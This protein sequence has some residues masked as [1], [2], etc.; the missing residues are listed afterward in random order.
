M[1]AVLPDQ[2]VQGRQ[3]RAVRQR[4]RHPPSGASP[5][6]GAEG[7]VLRPA[8]Q[9]VPRSD[10]P[11]GPDRWRRLRYGCCDGTRQRGR[12]HRRGR[13][14]PG[15]PEAGHRLPPEPPVPG[16]ACHALHERRP[17]LP[18]QHGQEVRPR[19]LRAAGL[20][21]PRQ[22]D[23][24]HP[25]RVVPVH[26]AVV[27][28]R[29]RSPLV[30]GRVRPLQLLP[31][32]VADLEDRRDARRDLCEP[33]HRPAV[34]RAQG[35]LR[36]RA[37]HRLAQ[38]RAAA[39]QHG[40]QGAHRWRPGPEGRHGR[41][42]IPLPA[43]PVHRAAL[44]RGPRVRLPHRAAGRPWRGAGR[45]HVRAPVQPALLRAGDGVPPAGDALA[46]ELLAAV[47]LHVACQR[48]RLL[49]DSCFRA[50]GDPRELQAEDPA[51]R[52]P[53]WAALRGTR[54]R[55]RAAAGIAPDRSAM[56]PLPARGRGRVCA[57]VPGKSRV[58][59]LV[60]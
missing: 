1:V 58:H 56:A 13:D 60:P 21:D 7:T 22:H 33:A 23:R 10:V 32:G 54:D 43:H 38:R 14:R 47:R 41:L 12:P 48:T 37:A 24:Q 16:S 34:R 51:R 44:P 42:A 53:V 28:I 5:G 29:P 52:A 19:H 9:V 20:A 25:A 17:R 50:A 8:L 18:A 46:R 49:R 55:L 6:R 26:G 39:C 4:E 45:R 2:H 27:R 57:G 30:D 36:G 15:H 59:V 40:R 11:G 31:R 35:H 3:R